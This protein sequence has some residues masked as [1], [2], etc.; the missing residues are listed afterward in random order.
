M[1]EYN[2]TS[3]VWVQLVVSV[4]TCLYFWVQ[5]HFTGPTSPSSL[6]CLSCID[7]WSYV[8]DHGQHVLQERCVPHLVGRHRLHWTSGG[9][10]E[11]LRETGVQRTIRKRNGG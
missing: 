4:H 6:G 5:S 3:I 1:G 8:G 7:T 11:A 10:G 2:W 9:C